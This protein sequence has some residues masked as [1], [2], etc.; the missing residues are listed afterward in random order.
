MGYSR[1]DRR[2]DR[3]KSP[4]GFNGNFASLF[5]GAFAVWQ[6]DRGLSYGGALLATAGNTSTTTLTLSGTILGQYVPIWVKATSNSPGLGTFDIYYDG[7]FAT[8]A[9]SGV[10]PTVGVPVALTGAGAGLSITWA[11]GSTVTNDTWKAT[12][13]ALADQSGNGKTAIQATASQQPLVAMGLNGKVAIGFDAVNDLLTSTLNLV[14]PSITNFS[15][16]TILAAPAGGTQPIYMG[17]SSAPTLVGPVGNVRQYDGALVNAGT[18]A[19]NTYTRIYAEFT[20]ST[21]DSLKVGANAAVTG[22]SSGNVGG[23]GFALGDYT[24]GTFPSGI[25]KMLTVV[26]PKLTAAQLAAIDAAVN[27]VAGYGVGGVVV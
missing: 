13:S 10:V 25:T 5:P 9:M 27:S 26:G 21:S 15:I 6:S 2:T 11:L 16:Y 19:A 14:A 4:S 22:A 20:G 18:M 17:I 1:R 8:P 23:N 24:G 7:A 3:R 12:Y